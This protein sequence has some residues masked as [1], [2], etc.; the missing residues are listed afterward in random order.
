MFVLFH[1]EIANIPGSFLGLFK[2]LIK[3]VSASQTCWYLEKISQ[4]TAKKKKK[5]QREKN[6]LKGENAQRP[7]GFVACV[8]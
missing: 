4:S 2:V 3:H 5:R 7:V 8:V 6:S 1:I